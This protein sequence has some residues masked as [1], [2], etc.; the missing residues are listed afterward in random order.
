MVPGLLVIPENLVW[1]IFHWQA[2]NIP[3]LQQVLLAVSPSW[4][5]IALHLSL[6]LEHNRM[7]MVSPMTKLSITRNV[8]LS[9]QAIDRR[10]V[11]SIVG[12]I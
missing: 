8:L 5:P 1:L 7:R 2:S 6:M 3:L 10:A 9:I 12:S 4:L 11:L